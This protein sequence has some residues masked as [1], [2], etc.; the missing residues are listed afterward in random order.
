MPSPSLASASLRVSGGA[1]RSVC[2]YRPP[3]PT[4]SPRSLVAS[5]MRAASGGGGGAG[6]R[7]RGGALGPDQVHGE[8][9]APAAPPPHDGQAGGRL[10]EPADD[11][12]AGDGGV[13]LQ[14]VRQQ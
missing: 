11:H 9:Q 14:V 4:S 10:P 8:H 5:S 13:A 6:G 12:L 3:L 7:A 1:I 2:P